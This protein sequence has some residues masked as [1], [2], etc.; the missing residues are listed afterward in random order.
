MLLP[1]PDP[2]AKKVTLTVGAPG[3]RKQEE[4][5]RSFAACACTSCAEASAGPVAQGNDHVMAADLF[6]ASEERPGVLELDDVMISRSGLWVFMITAA[7]NRGAAAV[8][9]AF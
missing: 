8:D 7:S 3:F 9:R 6:G 5:E 1:E 4:A 2:V